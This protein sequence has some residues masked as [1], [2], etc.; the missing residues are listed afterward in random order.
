[1]KIFRKEKPFECAYCAHYFISPHYFILTLLGGEQFGIC[2]K[3]QIDLTCDRCGKKLKIYS[4]F[5]EECT[6]C[7]KIFVSCKACSTAKL[8]LYE[9]IKDFFKKAVYLVAKKGVTLQAHPVQCCISKTDKPVVFSG[10]F[11]LK[12]ERKGGNLFKNFDQ[13]EH[14]Q[15]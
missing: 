5:L 11:Y 2:E 14:N 8:S 6:I 10:I 7:E 12:K 4:I 9:K 1:M 13:E 15:E 3:C